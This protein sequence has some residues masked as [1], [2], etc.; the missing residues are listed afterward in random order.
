MR[1]I[2]LP[3]VLAEQPAAVRTVELLLEAGGKLSRYELVRTLPFRHEVVYST[4]NDMLAA[5]VLSL[6]RGPRN[7]ADLS[8]EGVVDDA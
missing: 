2:E 1:P 8:L 3:E 4:L 7:R 5:G 6:S